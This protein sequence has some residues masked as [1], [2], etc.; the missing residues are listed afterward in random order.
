MKVKGVSLTT[1]IMIVL[2]IILLFWV[3]NMRSQDKR[4]HDFGPDNMGT[5]STNGDTS[6]LW[7]RV[8]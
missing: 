5:R 3:G 7:K 6:P 4:M 2:L 8:L 1:V